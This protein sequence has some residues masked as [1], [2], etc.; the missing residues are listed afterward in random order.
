MG[1]ETVKHI[2]NGSKQ[3]QYKKRRKQGLINFINFFINNEIPI[4]VQ[5]DA[6]SKFQ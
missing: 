6:T 4:K 2:E 1:L 5:R 3:R